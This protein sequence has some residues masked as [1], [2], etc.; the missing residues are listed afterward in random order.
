MLCNIKIVGFFFQVIDVE[1][2]KE[3]EVKLVVKIFNGLFVNQIDMEI[4]IIILEFMF[5]IKKEIK[6]EKLLLK[7]INLRILNK[8]FSIFQSNLI[9]VFKFF[10][11]NK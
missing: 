1:L 4:N 5:L 10:L 11:N 6:Q 2:E 7:L 8:N 9:D 3:I